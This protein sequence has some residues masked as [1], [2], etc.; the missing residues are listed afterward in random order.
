MNE[1]GGSMTANQKS[2]DVCPILHRRIAD[3][4][5]E[6]ETRK[7]M[8]QDVIDA[9]NDAGAARVDE[10]GDTLVSS[11][12]IRALAA[13]RDNLK[14]QLAALDWQPIT[15]DNLP[16]CGDEVLDIGGVFTVGTE[17]PEWNL[18]DWKTFGATHFRPI[19]A[20]KGS[21]P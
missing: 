11:N 3:L 17:E 4:E 2:C 16:K 12:R 10:D 8:Y 20:P 7:G 14:A 6:V 21:Q 15:A 13:E 9:L 19:N 1:Q 5:Q 18:L